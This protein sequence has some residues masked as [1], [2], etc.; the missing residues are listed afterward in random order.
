MAKDDLIGE[1]S[2]SELRALVPRLQ[3]LTDRYKR[4]EQIQKALY[5]ISE[6]SSSVNNYENLFSEIHNIVDGFMPA[7]N[8][9]VAFYEQQDDK[10]Q[11][12]Y[13]V[14]EQDQETVQSLSYEQIKHGMTAHILRSGENLIATKENFDELKEKH[15]FKIIGSLPVDFMGVPILRDNKVIGAMVVQS[16]TDSI[17]Y[18]ADD[19]EI[20][21]FISQHIVTARDR[22][23]Q[24]DLTEALIAD[25]TAKLVEANKTLEEQINER[26]RMEG[27][28][29]AL[30]E[31]SELSTNVETD[32]LAFYAQIHDI[33]K[34]LIEAKN[35][36]I[37]LLDKENENLSFPY[38]VGRNEDSHETR[39]L[40]RGLSEYVIRA[41]E[42]QLIDKDKINILIEQG[43]IGREFASRMIDKGNSWMGAP[44][45]VD[46]KV[47][48]IM[49]VQ[50]YGEGSDYTEDD[51]NLLRFVS[52]HIATAIQR[53]DSASKLVKYNQQLTEKV[54]ERTA[55]LNKSNLSLK[56]QI[57]Q[58]KE[59]ELKLIYDAHHDGLTNLPNR[60]MFNTRLE[61]AIASKKRYTEHNFAL[62]FIDLD[63]FKTINDTLGHHSGDLFLIE[64]A[65]RITACKRSH[66]L[67][68]RLGGDE[69][70]VLLDNFQSLD[71]AETIA[72]RIVES[73]SMP[74]Q[75]EDH[76]VFSGASVGIANIDESYNN[77]DE[78]LRDADAAMYQA[79]SLGR[80]RYVMFD[81]SM[82]HH[83]INKIND[84]HTFR[85]AYKAG[86]F[87][88]SL[89]PVVSLVD[90]SC[91]YS[92]C[93]VH[94]PSNEDGFVPATFWGLADKSGL[95]F[96]INADLLKTTF[97]VLENWQLTQEHKNNKI[98][99]SVCIEYLL[100]KDSFAE[101]VK[102]IE[103]NPW[104]SERLILLV[105]ER[106]LIR[107]AKYISTILL[108]L[109]KLGITL[110]LNNF[111]SQSASLNHLFNYDFDYIRLDAQL[112]NKFSLSDRSYLLA[113]SI[114]N[115]ANDIGV[116]VIAH[117]VQDEKIVEGLTEIGCHFAQGHYVNTKKAL[118][119]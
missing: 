89:T 86:E 41:G 57:E 49:A 68:A 111:A 47:K 35:C 112:I 39:K 44:L 1:L 69:F 93:Q 98:G 61:L 30:F 38:F 6:L 11:F 83:L 31:I 27:L 114:I 117:D 5:H 64:V 59:I 67:L 84:E 103:A 17:R 2:E 70:V 73:I 90:Q 16:Y 37:A 78:V 71:D 48:G 82:R 75:V 40:T 91:L 81:V 19:L 109:K 115:I 45:I 100:H 116:G 15:G 24:R 50:T 4:S 46:R 51:L 94:W 9:F 20:L 29:K 80:N 43:E 104:V 97:N 88:Y 102:N 62:L 28:Q 36:Y 107:F 26:K 96:A 7:D 21:V 23:I 113:K 54:Q 58:R 95:N 32:M 12:A 56:R 8:F 14:D 87:Q 63:R 3:H 74:F 99:V 10:I 13:F 65:N 53:R 106:D 101:L 66:D 108:P 119:A 79:K 85:K 33:L 22:V 77:A 110:V 55:E 42:A 76:E 105:S 60:V 72:R 25:R 52:R 92:E 118:I 34:P 18:D